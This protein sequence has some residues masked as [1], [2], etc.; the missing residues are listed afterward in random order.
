MIAHWEGHA[1]LDDCAIPFCGEEARQRPHFTEQHELRQKIMA[2][3]IRYQEIEQLKHIERNLEGSGL[4][5]R[6]RYDHRVYRALLA[7][8]SRRK[9]HL[10]M[11]FF[12]ARCTP[13]L[14][15]T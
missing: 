10:V 3:G 5:I 7:E 4:S 11:T 2:M 12:T 13:Y 9:G 1:V 14:N 15:D 6:R 8:W